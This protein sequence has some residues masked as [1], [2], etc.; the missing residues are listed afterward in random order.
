M[1]FPKIAHRRN[2]RH[3]HILPPQTMHVNVRFFMAEF[4]LSRSYLRYLKT[5]QNLCSFLMICRC[6]HC[7]LTVGNLNRK[8]GISSSDT[9]MAWHGTSTC[10]RSGICCAGGGG[11][12]KSFPPIAQPIG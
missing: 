8:F 4:I 10:D 1:E 2:D 5:K 6:L 9:R 12:E 11:G 3:I 7:L